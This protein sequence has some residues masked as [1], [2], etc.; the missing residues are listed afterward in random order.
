MTIKVS[1]EGTRELRGRAENL[2]AAQA[3]RWKPSRADRAILRALASRPLT[4]VRHQRPAEDAEDWD[5]NPVRLPDQ[6]ISGDAIRE[7]LSC[8]GVRQVNG[9]DP[10]VAL[11]L[12]DAAALQEFPSVAFAPNGT[13][14]LVTVTGFV[15]TAAALPP[16]WR[17][18]SRLRRLCGPRS[19]R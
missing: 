5:V 1:T 6:V 19:R 3:G 18:C 9:M 10:A 7:V 13:S 4:A 2:T 11:L 14:A 12:I 17:G 8:T 16:I 15:H